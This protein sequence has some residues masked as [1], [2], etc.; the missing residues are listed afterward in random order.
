MGEPA[1]QDFEAEQDLACVVHANLQEA[2][3]V[4]ALVGIEGAGIK[5][6]L[7]SRCADPSVPVGRH[8]EPG[9][10]KGVEVAGR[11]S[12]VGIAFGGGEGGTKSPAMVS[13]AGLIDPFD[14]EVILPHIPIRK[15]SV[16]VLSQIHGPGNGA[17][18]ILFP[19]NREIFI[20]VNIIKELSHAAEQRRINSPHRLRRNFQRKRLSTKAPLPFPEMQ[21]I[22]LINI[23][24]T[25]PQPRCRQ[26]RIRPRV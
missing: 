22:A 4:A 26:I 13:V 10:A 16:I 9:V 20:P 3:F 18:R 7:H 5:L 21:P 14:A 11:L 8:G 6:E 23:E 19:G 12:T 25:L 15:K 1:G 2:D 17:V 24:P